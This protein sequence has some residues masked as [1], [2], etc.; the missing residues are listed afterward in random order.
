LPLE[1]GGRELSMS[2]GNRK[3]FIPMGEV[4]VML[5]TKVVS[6]RVRV[7]IW[8]GLKV[9]HI[10]YLF[11]RGR[12]KGLPYLIMHNYMIK[13]ATPITSRGLGNTYSQYSHSSS[14]AFES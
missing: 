14:Q 12:G 8:P 1:F 10:G 11:T 13:R 2:L 5:P 6:I 9:V 4:R 7:M 3:R